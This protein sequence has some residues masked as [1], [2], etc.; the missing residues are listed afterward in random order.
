MKVNNSVSA[1]FQALV[2]TPPKGPFLSL[3]LSVVNVASEGH[4]QQN[5]TCSPSTLVPSDPV[6]RSN[7]Q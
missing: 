2:R 5:E 4:Q 7:W 3:G 6:I 1:P